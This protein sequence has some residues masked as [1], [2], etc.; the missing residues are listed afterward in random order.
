[1][2]YK[3]VRKAKA[4]STEKICFFILWINKARTIKLKYE[5]A[6][7][8]GVKEVAALTGP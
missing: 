8:H 2:I 3:N 4:F 1:M 6:N 5:T 7:K